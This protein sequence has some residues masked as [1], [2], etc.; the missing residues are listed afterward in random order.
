MGT[1]DPALLQ[2]L[3]LRREQNLEYITANPPQLITVETEPDE[4][5]HLDA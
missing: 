5:A 2:F 3:Q 4:Q 1:S